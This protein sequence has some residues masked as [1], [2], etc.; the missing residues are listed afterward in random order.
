MIEYINLLIL[1]ICVKKFSLNNSNESWRKNFEI[2]ANSEIF[3]LNNDP[4]FIG[5]SLKIVF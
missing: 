5:I 3:V 2:W 1:S 4:Y